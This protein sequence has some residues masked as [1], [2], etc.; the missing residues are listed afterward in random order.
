MNILNEKLIERKLNMN[1]DAKELLVNSL[2]D[3]YQNT[4]SEI[5]KILSMNNSNELPIKN[6]ML[7]I[8]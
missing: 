5:D 3:N 4:L 8:W 2:G 1:K 7:K 6:N